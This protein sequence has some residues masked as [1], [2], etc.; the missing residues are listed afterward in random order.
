MRLTELFKQSS[1][2]MVG[3][4]VRRGVGFLMIPVYTRYLSTSDYGILELIELFVMVAGVYFG[5]LAISD[6]MVRIY[7][8]YGEGEK[9]GEVIS[10]AVAGVAICG[11]LVAGI[12]SLA[13][14]PLSNLAFGGGHY[15]SLVRAS[16]VALIF[17][18]LT[19][20]A[21]TYQRLR[22]R[23]A[24]FVVF[25]IVQLVVNIAL[26]VYFIAYLK[27][28]VWGFVLA[29]LVVC[30]LGSAYLL[31]I[32]IRETGWTLSREA[33]A[34][35]AR[36]GAPLVF[37]G[38]A[39]FIIHFA[40]RF[41][42]NHY[43]SLSD[44]GIYALAYKFGFLVSYAVGQPF[45]STWSVRLYAHTTGGRWRQNFARVAGYLAFFLV[46][47]AVAL[48]LF[49][50]KLLAFIATPAYLPAAALIPIVAFG[51]VFREMGDFFRGVLFINKR[52]ALFSRITVACAA[53]NLVLNWILISKYKAAG[54][55]WAT[56]LTWLVYMVAC[57][58][59]AAREHEIPYSAKAFAGL[60]LLAAGVCS[61]L[62]PVR[63]LPLAWQW[64][65]SGVL[66]AM[67]AGISWI[68]GYFNAEERDSIRQQL[69]MGLERV[70]K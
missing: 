22:Q 47:A 56:L 26:N 43:G 5:M 20:I 67:F 52:V 65:S 48:G 28:G 49:I 41:F 6:G 27:L 68:A 16:F 51:Y 21:L 54:A 37:S 59:Q 35:I 23:A 39:I 62:A 40:D 8:D 45:A 69:A 29:K 4:F 17:S 25:S 63:N 64:L 61:V 15:A 55:A 66:L 46:L 1:I 10:T 11:L 34:R 50:D 44:V 36:F 18:S 60:C 32:L 58:K 12:A 33:A 53:L 19:D 13:A 9:R 30:T 38:G 24:L 7:H 70:F 31:T 57:W 3:E 42:V 14:T 2:Y